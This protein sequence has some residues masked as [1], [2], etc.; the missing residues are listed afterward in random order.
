MSKPAHNILVVQDND[1]VQAFMAIHL[2]TEGYQVKTAT[3]GAEMFHALTNDDPDLV[4][5]ELNLPDGDGLDLIKRIRGQSKTP[6][7]VATMRQGREACLKALRLGADDYITKP[8]D[9]YE[10]VLRIR[11]ILKYSPPRSVH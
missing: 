4:L 9:L 10:M 7:L 3:N 6:I 2:E 5:M 1:L 8:F 11:N